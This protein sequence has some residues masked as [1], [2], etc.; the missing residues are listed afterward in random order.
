MTISSKEQT[1]KVQITVDKDP[2]PTSFD[3]W[4][5]TRKYSII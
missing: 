4:G 1:K 5:A 2:V 3:K